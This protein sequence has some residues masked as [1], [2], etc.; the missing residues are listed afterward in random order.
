MSSIIQIKVISLTQILLES[1]TKPKK[2]W[3]LHSYVK[4]WTLK[5]EKLDELNDNDNHTN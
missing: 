5:W 2:N 3:A 4:Q 1:L